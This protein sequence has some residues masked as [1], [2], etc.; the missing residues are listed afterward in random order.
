MKKTVEP[1]VAEFG[2]QISL[3]ESIWKSCILGKER[4]AFILLDNVIEFMSKCYL[5]VVQKL[6]GKRKKNKITLDEW[7]DISRYFGELMATMRV[8]SPIQHSTIDSIETHHDARNILYHTSMPMAVT[9]AQF[10]IEL[11][12][13]IEV[14]QVLYDKPYKS[15]LIDVDATL[16]GKPVLEDVINIV[17]KNEFV[18]I[19]FLGN[20]SLKQWIRVII[21]GYVSTL[22]ITPSIDQIQ[23]S[24]AISN[25]AEERSQID[26]A[27]RNLKH[28]NDVKKVGSGLY[29][30]TKDG[31]KRTLRNR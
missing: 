21:H 15:I 25:Q 7:D 1:W 19:Q 2:F 31:L 26:Q 4:I 14:F 12:N 18:R 5:M 20:W 10:K 9:G 29:S 16:H 8:H 13:A 11:K 3:A 22:G 30:L 28:D 23:H 17:G 24:L 27:L 6:V